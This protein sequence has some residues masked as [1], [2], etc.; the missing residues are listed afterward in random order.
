M[1]GINSREH[2]ILAAAFEKFENMS[3][4]AQDVLEESEDLQTRKGMAEL[5][6]LYERFQL[7]YNE[8]EKCIKEYEGK[9]KTVRSTIN[10]SNRKLISELQKKCIFKIVSM[11]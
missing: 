2:R 8:L 9:K 10:R 3:L 11:I 7:L 6:R 5:D 4:I 1:Q